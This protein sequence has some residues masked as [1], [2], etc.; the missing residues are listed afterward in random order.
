MAFVFCGMANR[1]LL[2]S[3]DPLCSSVS[4]YSCRQ[5]L[6]GAAAAAFAERIGED[7][8]GL[9]RADGICLGL[10]CENTARVRRRKNQVRLLAADLVLA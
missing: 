10:G 5:P 3:W 4:L 8:R 9:A 6:T 7:Q 2:G 1:P